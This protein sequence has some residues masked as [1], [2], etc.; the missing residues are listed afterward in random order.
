M[1]TKQAKTDRLNGVVVR[2]F[3]K[4]F[5]VRVEGIDYS[6]GVRL[7]VKLAAG[8]VTPVTVGDDVEISDLGEG[9]GIIESVGPR[10]TSFFRPSKGRTSHKQALAANID[11]LAIVVS[12]DEPPLKPRLIDRFTVVA[13]LGGLK[14][15]VIINKTDLGHPALVDEL[16]V[17][18]QKIDIQAVALSASSG[19]GLERLKELLNGKRTLFVGHSGVGKSTLVNAL[20]PGLD[21]KTAEVSERTN[22]GR[23]TTTRVE[24]HP[25]PF[26]GFLVDSPGLKILS[27]WEVTEKNLADHFVEFAEYTGGCRFNDCRHVSEPSCG[28]KSA[29]DQGLIPRFRYESYLSILDSLINPRAGDRSFED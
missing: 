6:C 12:V 16:I 5:T 19:S 21:L 25:L 17:G 9:R 29:L 18:Y 7:N 27:L 11:Q 2:A 3:G 24:L 28:V 10:R 4:N 1:N 15:L 8:P 14:P 22:K 20:L 23:H 26:G 13:E